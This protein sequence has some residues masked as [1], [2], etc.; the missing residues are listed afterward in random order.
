LK[1]LEANI[2]TSIGP[3]FKVLEANIADKV[4][5]EKF[6]KYMRGVLDSYV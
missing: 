1:E 2:L 4:D 5:K 6:T 3:T